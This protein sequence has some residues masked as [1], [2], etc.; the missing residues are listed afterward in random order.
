MKKAIALLLLSSTSVLLNSAAIMLSVEELMKSVT[1]IQEI[2][3]LSFKGDSVMVYQNVKNKEVMELNC[4]W[5]TYSDKS[6]KLLRERYPNNDS[7]EGTFPDVGETVMMIEHDYAGSGLLFARV[8][9]EYYRFWDPGS[10]PFAN[11]VFFFPKDSHFEPTALC[12]SHR[13]DE[14]TPSCSD[15]FRMK[16]DAF[17]KLREVY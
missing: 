2:K 3:V 10:V 16:K 7:W 14:T 15:G 9:N 11:S 5:K 4:G 1:S 17:E 8:E 12:L 13:T 6:I